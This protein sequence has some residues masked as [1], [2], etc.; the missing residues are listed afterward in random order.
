MEGL[1]FGGFQEQSPMQTQ[2]RCSACKHG[3]HKEHQVDFVARD[4]KATLCRCRACV[5][6]EFL[7]L[8]PEALPDPIV[9]HV[10]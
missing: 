5:S 8:P 3:R 2:N 10:N 1:S 4:G 9:C 6:R 7:E